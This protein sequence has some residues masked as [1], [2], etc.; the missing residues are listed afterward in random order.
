MRFKTG[1]LSYR[2]DPYPKSRGVPELDEEEKEINSLKYHISIRKITLWLLIIT[3]VLNFLG[4]FGRG[5]EF[6]L[7][8][9]ETTEIVR[10]V[11]VAEKGNL[12]TWFSAMLL[13]FSSFLLAF[14][15]RTI[16]K[17]K[18]PFMWHWT[19]LSLIFFLMSLGEA[20]R[21]HELT[22]EALVPIFI[23]SKVFRN[24]WVI[25]AILLF[26]FVVLTYANYLNHLPRKSRVLFIISGIIFVIAA[27]GIDIFE[28][29]LI[30]SNSMPRLLEPLLITIEELVENLAIVLFIYALL[31]Y[32]KY[33]LEISEIK[34]HIF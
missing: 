6:L 25:L 23:I 31:S 15:S 26:S 28:G 10:L 9:K 16:Y 27:V 3:L 34:L 1:Q 12:T 21:I 5:V 18:K 29:I 22:F 24:I 13:F 7:G 2:K 4:V 32:I 8:I 33:P 11:H 19:F 20:A 30:S 14:I 17:L